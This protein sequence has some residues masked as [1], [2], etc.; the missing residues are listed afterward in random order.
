[1]KSDGTPILYEV[2][3][4][5]THWQKFKGL[6]FKKSLGEHQALLLENCR[7]IHSSFMRMSI[8]VIFMDPQ[9]TIVYLMENMRPWRISK[10]VREGQSVLECHSGTIRKH[11]LKLH[12]TLKLMK[13]G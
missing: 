13:R 6:M 11:G 1:M 3:R 4:A 12:D 7:S 9:G 2:R 10:I 8:D 5:K